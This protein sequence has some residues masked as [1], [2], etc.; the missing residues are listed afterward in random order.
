M[1]RQISSIFSKY[2][3]LSGDLS[4]FK[5]FLS[6]RL[7]E[8]LKNESNDESE[9]KEI[10]SLISKIKKVELL[11]FHHSISKRQRES[12]NFLRTNI[13]NDTI[14]IEFDFK[15]KIK[16]GMSPEQISQ[17]YFNM[18]SRYVLGEFLEFTYLF[19]RLNYLF[20]TKGLE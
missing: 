13:P 5:Q 4:E 3:F 20:H 8:L 2:G 17:E 11:D 18:K 19:L 16:I 15:E 7:I 10:N 12:Y 1:K 6:K 14:F 9:I